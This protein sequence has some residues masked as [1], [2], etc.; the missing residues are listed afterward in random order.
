[1]DG[2]REKSLIPMFVRNATVLTGIDRTKGF[3]LK[4]QFEMSIL[5][6]LAENANSFKTLRDVALAAGFKGVY[7]K[8]FKSAFNSLTRSGKIRLDQF[9]WFEKDEGETEPIEMKDNTMQKILDGK[10][11]PQVYWK[12]HPC[13]ECGIGKPEEDG[14]YCPKYGWKISQKL[15]EIQ[16]LC[17]F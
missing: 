7:D 17:I 2:F 13:S 11:P 10:H 16:Q 8:N 6:A 12:K 3:I 9:G 1:M 4:N 15:A 5:K 14:V